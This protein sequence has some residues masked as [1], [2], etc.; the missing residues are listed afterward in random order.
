MKM[1]KKTS[2]NMIYDEI[3]AF[4]HASAVWFGLQ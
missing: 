2:K 4:S 1:K 3:T